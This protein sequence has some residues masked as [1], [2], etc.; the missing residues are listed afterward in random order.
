MRHCVFSG[1]V[2]LALSCLGDGDAFKVPGTVCRLQA[3]GEDLVLVV[4][5]AAV[6]AAL[7]Q[8]MCMHC[9]GVGLALSEWRKYR[10]FL[11]PQPQQAASSAVPAI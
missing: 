9:H 1:L 5:V 4:L 3:V 7:Q 11:Q 2:F 10:D 8:P 6:I